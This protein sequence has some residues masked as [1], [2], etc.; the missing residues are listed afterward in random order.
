[1]T[2]EAKIDALIEALNAN[3]QALTGKPARGT[4][5]PTPEGSNAGSD[6]VKA[7]D[8]EKDVKPPFLNL[9][10]SHG[11]EFAFKAVSDVEP[12]FNGTGDQQPSLK[13]IIT[14]PESF[15][16]VLAAI[17]AA[18]AQPKPTKPAKD[19]LA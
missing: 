11:K 6:Q 2:I 1:M 7:L 12:A 10:K 16:K 5:A 9:V 8:Y 17:Q 3:T 18:A 13:N 14:K 15:A 4:P 19:D